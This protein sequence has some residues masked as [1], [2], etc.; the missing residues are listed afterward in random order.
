MRGLRVL[1]LDLLLQ[2]ADL[3]FGL[4]ESDV[5]DQ[6]GLRQHV[7]CIGIRAELLI[8][9]CFGVGILFLKLCLVDALDEGA[10]KLFFLGSQRCNLR[11]PA[12]AGSGRLS[13]LRRDPAGKVAPPLDS[14]MQIVG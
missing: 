9:Q 6:Y 5:L 7:E 13:L 11:R 8:Q 4:V 3:G 1:L 14:T 12:T 2:L 10:K